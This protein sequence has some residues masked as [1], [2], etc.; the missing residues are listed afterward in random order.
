[1]KIKA[2][3]YTLDVEKVTGRYVVRLENG[4]ALT[5]GATQKCYKELI[6]AVTEGKYDDYIVKYCVVNN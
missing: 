4:V 3:K 1:M 5:L 6:A 2:G